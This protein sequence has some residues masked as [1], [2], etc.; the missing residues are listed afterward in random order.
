MDGSVI[1]H[2]SK[3]GQEQLFR[4]MSRGPLR[5]GGIVVRSG[6]VLTTG[7][8]LNQLVGGPG[9]YFITGAE[10][11]ISL[12]DLYQCSEY[13]SVIIRNKLSEKVNSINHL[14]NEPITLYHFDSY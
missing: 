5:N 2:Q 14:Q 3:R 11:N 6:S 1:Y 8:T 12:A 13:L 9:S 4:G 10:L 7:S